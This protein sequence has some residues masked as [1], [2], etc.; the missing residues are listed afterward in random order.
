MAHYAYVKMSNTTFGTVEDV[1]SIADEDEN[2]LEQFKRDGLIILKTSYNTAD[3]KHY[4]P[5]TGEED[6]GIQLRWNYAGIGHIYDADRD[7]FYTSSPHPSWILNETTLKWEPPT[8]WKKPTD[9][10]NTD[11]FNRWEWDEENLKWIPFDENAVYGERIYGSSG[12]WEVNA[13]TAPSD[14]A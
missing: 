5:E 10:I 6:D 2:D 13:N 9:V 7:V 1:I 12:R 14:D 4:D 8:G 3:G 11:K